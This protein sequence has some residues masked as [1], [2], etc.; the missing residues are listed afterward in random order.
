MHRLWLIFTQTVTVS[1]A[2]F[3]VISTLR[4]EWLAEPPGQ[5]KQ[6]VALRESPATSGEAVTS[7]LTGMPHATPCRR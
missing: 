2:V 5:E 3:F 7:L 1:L 4:P 6:V